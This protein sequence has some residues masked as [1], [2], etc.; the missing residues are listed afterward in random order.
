MIMHPVESYV[1]RLMGKRVSEVL[2]G[3]SGFHFCFPPDRPKGD[4][5]EE[6]GY[7]LWVQCPIFIREDPD[8]NKSDEWIQ[9]EALE[10]LSELVAEQMLVSFKVNP[11]GCELELA[12]DNVIFKLTPSVQDLEMPWG[13]YDY[14]SERDYSFSVYSDYFEGYW[15]V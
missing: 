9:F 4:G 3:P 5:K 14:N 11:A 10:R 2:V 6:P 8:K 12:F 15:A 7:S 1:A 13:I